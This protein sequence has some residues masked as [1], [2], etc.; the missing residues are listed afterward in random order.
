MKTVKN[1][2]KRHI[3][4]D[5]VLLIIGVVCLS[6][7]AG[8]SY[9]NAMEEKRSR[10]TVQQLRSMRDVGIAP[11]VDSSQTDTEKQDA[12]TKQVADR[13]KQQQEQ[14]VA[15]KTADPQ[16]QTVKETLAAL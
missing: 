9:Y 8:I 12:I 2:H 1:G 11:R 16:A 6:I 10:E 7:F 13:L 15:A 3:R 4:L 5:A 14:Q